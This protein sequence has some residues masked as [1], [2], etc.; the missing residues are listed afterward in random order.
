MDVE[1]STTEMAEWFITTYDLSAEEV[2]TLLVLDGLLSES[3]AARL[4]DEGSDQD[5]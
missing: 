1:L 4:V 5:G 2:R 3:E